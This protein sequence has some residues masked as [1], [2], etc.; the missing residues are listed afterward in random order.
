M[1]AGSGWGRASTLCPSHGP[2]REV[3]EEEEEEEGEGVTALS[4][5]T[6]NMTVTTHI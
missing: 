2:S 1:R 6:V 3:E 5:H 4:S